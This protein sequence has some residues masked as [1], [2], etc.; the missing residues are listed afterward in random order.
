[1]DGSRPEQELRALADRLGL[2][3]SPQDWGVEHADPRRLGE[4]IH[5]YDAA[6][7]TETQ[8][9]NLYE[10][11]VCTANDA[12]LDG[13]GTDADLDAFR[14]FLRAHGGDVPVLHNYWLGLE[15]DEFPIADMMRASP[16]S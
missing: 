9:Y 1:M 2:P 10:L 8:R 12:V 6:D 7:L 13:G 16:A 4:F 11:I 14:N 5:E 15:G 3:F